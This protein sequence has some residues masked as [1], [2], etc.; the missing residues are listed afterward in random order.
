[1]LVLVFG[2]A[3]TVRSGM[4]GPDGVHLRKEAGLVLGAVLALY[5]FV[6]FAVSLPREC[7]NRACVGRP[8]FL[9]DGDRF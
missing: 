8:Y 5:A 3:G 6:P 9:D 7:V 4:M 2:D 1:M